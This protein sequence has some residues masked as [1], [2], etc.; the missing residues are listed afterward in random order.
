MAIMINCA[1][2]WTLDLFAEDM[3]SVNALPLRKGVRSAKSLTDRQKFC[4]WLK[5]QAKFF[6]EDYADESGM[7]VRGT[8]DE[9]GDAFANYISDS[10]FSDWYK[11]EYNQRPHF[12]RK[13]VA[14]LCGLPVMNEVGFCGSGY[15]DLLREAKKCAKE[16]REKLEAEAF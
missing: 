12:S 14:M 6:V 3:A 11:D 1:T 8:Y 9:M 7:Y 4:Q 2:D 5:T 10:C 16:V 13:F 15:R